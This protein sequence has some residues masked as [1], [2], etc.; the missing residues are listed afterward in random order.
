GF[1]RFDKIEYE[2]KIGIIAGTRSSGYF[3]IRSLSGERIHDS[4]KYSKL[5]HFEKSKT[6]MLER[7][8]AAISSH[9]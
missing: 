6:I 5:K 9:D 2:G 4:V 1:R 7:R 3:V 8:E